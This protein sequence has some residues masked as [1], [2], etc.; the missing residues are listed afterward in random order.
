MWIALCWPLRRSN[1]HHSPSIYR[2]DLESTAQGSYSAPFLF[3]G[4]ISIR[5]PVRYICIYSTT[6]PIHLHEPGMYNQ[7]LL[8]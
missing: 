8:F 7:L 2:M 4:S 6:A 1:R 3:R 5:Q